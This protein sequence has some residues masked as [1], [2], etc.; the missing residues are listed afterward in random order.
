MQLK[1][2]A[3][4]ILAVAVLVPIRAFAQAGRAELFGV[5]RDASGL[6]VPGAVVQAEDQG[7]MVRYSGTSDER[8]EYHLV[9]LPASNYVVTVEQPRFRTYRQSG[10]TL[11]LAERVP[12]DVTLEIGQASQTVEVT[13][14]A[15]VLQTGSGEVGMNMDEKKVTTL[16]LDGRNFIPLVTMA[17]GVALPGGGSVLPRING[18]RPRTNEYMYDGISVLQPEPGQVVYYPII[19]G[20]AEFKLNVNAYSPEYGRSNGGTVMVIGKSGTNQFHGSAFEFFRNEALNARNYFA[21][22]GPKP[23]FRRNIYGLTLGGP[24]QA[25]KTFF[26]TDWQGTRLRTGITR[27]SVVPTLAQRQGIFT[28]AIFDPGTAGRPQFQNNTIPVGRFD[29]IGAQILQHYPLPN[30]AGANNYVRTAT[31]PDDQDQ[32]DFRVDRYFGEQHRFFARYTYFRDDDTPV[33][34]LPDGSGSLTS[35]VIGHAITRG[36]AVVGDYSWTVSPTTLNQF[37]V[38]YSRRDLNQNSLQNGGITIPGL[39][40]NS[41]G[42]V[43]PIFTVA[44]FQ[45]I[46]PTTAANSNFTT[47]ITEFLDTFTMVRGRHTIKLGTDIRREALD[48]LNPPNPTGA[49]SFTTTGTNSSTVANS[50]NA[51][52]S[53]LLGQ[54]NSFTIDIQNRVIQERAHIAEFFIGDDWKVSSRLTVN[55]GTRYT[56]N[57]PSTEVHDQGAV[58]NLSTQVLDFPHTARNL[59]CCDFG[60]RLGLAYR[61]A[62]SLVV[63][64]GYGLVF[65]EQSG[66]TTPFTMPQFPFIQTVG[67]QSQDNVNAAFALSSGPTVQVTAPNPNSGLGQGVFS[68]DRTNGSGYSQQ[69]NLTIGKSFQDTW[70][71]EV[72]YLGSKNTRLG[73]PDA[74]INQLPTQYLSMG[75]ALLA[76]VPNPYFG[77]IPASSSLGGATI[78]QQQLLRPFPRFTTVALFRDNV[79]NS[80]YNAF[81]LKVEKRLAQGLALNASYTFS[82]LIDD[83]SSVFSQTI[84]TGPVLNSTGAA[85]AY[86][87]HLER[88]LSSGDIP[89]VF[90]IGWTYDIPRLWKVSGV[91]IAGL[92]RVQAGDTV[93][94]TQATNNNSS[95]GFAV[96]RPNRIGNPNNFVGRSAAKYFDTSAF[97]AAPQFVIGSSSRDPVRGPGLQDADLMIGKT[98]AIR[99]KV[100]L[101]LRAEAF[102][103][104][105]TP[106]LADPN[107][108]FGSAA[109]G[110]IISAGNPRVFE[111]VGKIHF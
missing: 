76:K 53:M 20:I 74:N 42:S 50:G 59:E 67:Q 107:G 34:P 25:N 23:E 69:R 93:P 52:A 41:F 91:Q 21:Q 62:D 49:F 63:R 61:I 39:P 85:D 22:P 101:E 79:G 68:V 2:Y 15:P 80:T 90:A 75:A 94:V 65:F 77:L 13:A 109:F 40:A 30:V 24:I 95:L 84:F 56:L 16:P 36:D 17:P 3:A 35:G 6:P 51:F 45:Q 73:I 96:Q 99:E 100:N 87:R 28:Q 64:A 88:D 26:F 108:S 86:N 72:A 10:L 12:L 14:A 55:A 82:K 103:V 78:T 106:P 47:S 81:A 48:V 37:R 111:L 58:F 9:G 54:V 11:R 89:Q 70:N 46:G 31:E 27:F 105:N 7:T 32:A 44:G 98:F 18:S 60:P 104:S 5:I 71:I 8:G 29:S 57:F 83:A 110:T 43:L 38:G 97:T 4:L 19:D 1:R 92:V 33:T 102:N 66:I